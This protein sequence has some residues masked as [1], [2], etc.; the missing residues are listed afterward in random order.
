MLHNKGLSVITKTPGVSD[1]P[2]VGNLFRG[3]QKSDK[4]EEMLIF[5]AP[6]V[7]D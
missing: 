3:K 6:R 7:I 1:A 4:L 2:I 5:L